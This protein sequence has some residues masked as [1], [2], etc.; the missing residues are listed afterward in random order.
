MNGRGVGARVNL[1]FNIEEIQQWKI[2]LVNSADVS[3]QWFRGFV[4]ARYEIGIKI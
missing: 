4:F 2:C 1:H 3:F